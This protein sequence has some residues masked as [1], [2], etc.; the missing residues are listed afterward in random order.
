MSLKDLHADLYE[1]YYF[2]QKY[3]GYRDSGRYR[4]RAEKIISLAHKAGINAGRVLDVGCAYGYTVRELQRIGIEAVGLDV[5][6][7]AGQKSKTVCFYYVRASVTHLP[8][9]D[10]CFDVCYSEGTLEHI[11]EPFIDPV[12]KEFERVSKLRI[13]AIS[14]VDDPPY[15]LC[16]HP[17]EWWL[18]RIPPNSYLLSTGAGSEAP[19]EWTLKEAEKRSVLLGDQNEAKN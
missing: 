17:Y 7:Y 14:W 11:A 10:K 3:E 6:R 15:H 9:K 13:L 1:V 5:S 2:E 8:F 12:L 18:Q 16:L 4:V 19:G